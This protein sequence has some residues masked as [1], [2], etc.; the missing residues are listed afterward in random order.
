MA[1]V[2]KGY[3]FVN[4][5]NSNTPFDASKTDP[6]SSPSSSNPQMTLQSAPQAVSESDFEKALM[7][8]PFKSGYSLFFGTLDY[9]VLVR[10]IVMIYERFVI[11]K[12]QITEK[13]A[14]D[15]AS[16]KLIDSVAKETRQPREKLLAELKSRQ[17]E[18]TEER[19]TMFVGSVMM[20][21]NK[22]SEDKRS[23][24]EDITRNLT[25][26]KAYLLFDF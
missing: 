3:Q 16:N 1:K 18:M 15:L 14:E 5:A 2:A 10:R 19:F 6:E 22:A 4:E 17:A 26:S 23:K 21:L 13:V 8:P 24:Y 7:V 9:F 25:G 12:T 20:T 11:A